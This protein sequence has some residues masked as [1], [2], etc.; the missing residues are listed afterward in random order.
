MKDYADAAIT[1]S[2]GP[3]VPWLQEGL[4]HVVLVCLAASIIVPFWYMLN[5]SLKVPKEIFLSGY[6]FYPPRVTWENYADVIYR[7][8]FLRWTLNSLLVGSVQTSVQLVVA[9]LGAY[10][11]AR[12]RFFG[13]G[14]MFFMVLSTMMIPPQAFMVPLYV[15]VNRLGWVNAY[16][17]IIVPHLAS[18]YAVFLLRQFFLSIPNELS[19]AAEI[20]GCNSLQILRYVYL[21]ASG[22]VLTALAVIL[23]VNSWNDYYWPLIVITKEHLRTI[24]LALVY[25]RG[26]EGLILWGPTMAAA[27][28]ATIPILAL[29]AVAQRRFMEGFAHTGIKG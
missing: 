19:E 7:S 14:F 24:P 2:K 3:S 1:Y 13:R 18:G 12:Y 4:K 22:T 29:Y 5:T 23:F 6:W 15:I 25:F 17:G 8:L 26:E 10:A 16:A 21:P 27:T 20:D 9:L 28:M 11:F